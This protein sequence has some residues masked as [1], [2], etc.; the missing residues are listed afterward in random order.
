MW[1]DRNQ[2]VKSFKTNISENMEKEEKKIRE[3]EQE[4]KAKIK[5]LE[6]L[7]INYSNKKIPKPI[8]NPKLKKKQRRK[9]R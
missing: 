3:Q 2:I 5:E 7:K 1:N 4:K 6:T 9:K 8:I